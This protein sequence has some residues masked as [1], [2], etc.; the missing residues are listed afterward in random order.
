[1]SRTRGGSNSNDLG[2]VNEFEQSLG[3][4]NTPLDD[5]AASE[6]TL[7][8]VREGY[9]EQELEGVQ[10]KNLEQHETATELPHAPGSVKVK[11]LDAKLREMLQAQ[12]AETQVTIARMFSNA[13]LLDSKLEFKDGYNHMMIGP[14]I[15]ADGLTLEIPSGHT[16]LII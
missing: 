2:G 15:I 13:Q 7:Q 6:R 11:H 10:T 14:I 16:L 12:L 8:G 3:L 1:M 5:E 4:S 9:F